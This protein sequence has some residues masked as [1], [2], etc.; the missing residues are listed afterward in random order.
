M[1][2][3]N[4]KIKSYFLS[5]SFLILALIS[6][7]LVKSE[8]SFKFCKT[9]SEDSCIA[10]LSQYPLFDSEYKIAAN[11]VPI[12]PLRAFAHAEVYQKKK[13]ARLKRF[14]YV[15]ALTGQFAEPYQVMDVNIEVKGIGLLGREI[16]ATGKLNDFDI[17]YRNK[18]EC[19]IQRKAT[20]DVTAKL[21]GVKFLDLDIK[22]DGNALTNDVKGS[23]FAKKVD[24]Q[25]HWRTTNGQLANLNYEVYTEGVVK[26]HNAFQAISKGKIGNVEINGHGRLVSANYYEFEEQY[27]PIMVKSQLTIID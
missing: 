22:S 19:T 17:E 1:L 25:T 9:V 27:G 3:P 10:S 4:Q 6:P 18:I 11:Y 12:L 26:E 24:Y 15:K 8:T 20:M 13:K 21:A 14:F 2:K 16:I 23:F 7:S 5:L